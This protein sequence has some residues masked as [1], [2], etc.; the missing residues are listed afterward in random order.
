MSGR[1]V[2]LASARCDAPSRPRSRGRP[3]SGSGP[4]ASTAVSSPSSDPSYDPAYRRGVSVRRLTQGVLL[5]RTGRPSLLLPAVEALRAAD[6]RAVRVRYRSAWTPSGPLRTEAQSA[7]QPPSDEPWSVACGGRDAAPWNAGTV[8]RFVQGAPTSTRAESGEQAWAI[9]RNE[10][11]GRVPGPR[12][13]VLLHRGSTS[14]ASSGR[15]RGGWLPTSEVGGARR[16]SI[17]AHV[18]APAVW[19]AP[20]CGSLTAG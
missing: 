17:T 7:D 6:G 14:V 2:Q 12:T 1:P 18:V 13:R 16:G 4:G 5:P 8:H 15:R 19:M 20:R 3:D 10:A 9:A 11:A